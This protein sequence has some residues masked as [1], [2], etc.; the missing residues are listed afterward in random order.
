M[1]AD[2]AQRLRAAAAEL[3][4]GRVSVRHLLEV[5]GGAAHASLL[6]L[7]AAPCLLPIPGVGAAFSLGLALLALT[8]WRRTEGAHLPERIAQIELPQAWAAKLL[9]L[10]A[11]FYSLTAMLAKPRWA[12]LV[13]D[14]AHR[15]VA[16]GA[17]LMALLIFLPIPFGNVLP[18]VSLMLAGLALALRDGLVLM[19]ALFTGLTAIG[20]SA[21]VV[22]LALHWAQAAISLVI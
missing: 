20:T 19:L 1:S 13:G 15:W 2:I 7:L 22:T 12:P 5:H 11:S 3:P 4:A 9:R 16:P 10:L 8:L 21:V 14:A 18:A 6:V 17:A